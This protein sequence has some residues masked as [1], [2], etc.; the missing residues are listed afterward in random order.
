MQKL[1]QKGFELSEI[2]NSSGEVDQIKFTVFSYIGVNKKTKKIVLTVIAVIGIIF[3]LISYVFIPIFCIALLLILNTKTI[4][5]SAK[6]IAIKN[7]IPLFPKKE[8]S[9]ENIEKFKVERVETRDS[10]GKKSTTFVLFAHF[11]DKSSKKIYTNLNPLLVNQMDSAIEQFL[12][13]TDNTNKKQLDELKFP[14]LQKGLKRET[15][16]E[17]KLPNINTSKPSKEYPFSVKSS[18]ISD[19]VIYFPKYNQ[20]TLGVFMLI[21]GF[22]F[23][24]PCLP[25]GIPFFIWGLKKLVNKQYV[26]VYYNKLSYNIKPISLKKQKELFK[27]HISNIEV[28]PSNVTTNGVMSYHL[29]ATTKDGKTIKLIRHVYKEAALRNICNKITKR[30]DLD[31]D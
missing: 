31:R 10:K 17:E 24:F 23:S 20:K 7:S 13:I 21:F 9:I 11:K 4:H 18:L 27:K 14:N 12:N 3:C 6:K 5:V 16:V 29:L 30:L 19:K 26:N 15:I 8:F 2:K 25:V 1:S 22:F 28:T